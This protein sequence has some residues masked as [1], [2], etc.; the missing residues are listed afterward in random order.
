MAP[1]KSDVG[2]E[3]AWEWSQKHRQVYSFRKIA[4]ESG[5]DPRYVAKIVRRMERAIGLRE[6]E[7]ARSLVAAETL[8]HHHEDLEETAWKLL[9]ALMPPIAVD[10]VGQWLRHADINNIVVELLAGR[11]QPFEADGAGLPKRLKYRIA[12][13]RAQ[14][15]LE[16]LREH[17]SEEPHLWEVVRQL[18][19]LHQDYAEALEEVQSSYQ[20]DIGEAIR[21]IRSRPNARPKP[22]TPAVLLE[23]VWSLEDIERLFGQLE[24]TLAPP[25]LHKILLVTRCRHCPLP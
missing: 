23:A 17:L 15:A 9:E 5:R 21:E 6:A 11:F 19:Q 25:Q 22:G 3:E 20:G 7:G 2:E 1:R 10:S 16:G 14:A 24:A 4:Q 12:R 8:K 18:E 13:V